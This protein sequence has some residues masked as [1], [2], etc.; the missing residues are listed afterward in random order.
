MKRL[1]LLLIF[2]LL[3]FFSYGKESIEEKVE[4]LIKMMTLEEKIGQMTQVDNSYLLTPEDIKNYYIGSVLSGGNSGPSEFTPQ[5][6]ADYIDTL[7]SYALKTRLRIPLLYGI[8]AVHGNGK[9]YSAVIFPHNIGLGCTRDINLVERCARITALESCAIGAYWSFAP[10]VA[11]VQDIR[12]GRT[13][14]S[15]S[16]DPE[17]V[18]QMAKAVIRGFHGKFLNNNDSILACP[19]H[20]VGDGG[21]KFG[22]GIN[23]LLDQGDTRISEKLLREIHLK[24]YI[25]AIE[26]GAKSIMVSF[27]SF[28]GKKIHGNKYL[29]T[30][31]LKGELKFR[32]FLVSDWKGIEQLQGNYEEQ[33]TTAINAG[34]DMVMVPDDYRKFINTLIDCVKKGKISI[35]RINDAVRRILKVKFEMGLFEHP[36]GNR[37]LLN[38]IGSEEHRKVA[39]EAVRKSLVILKNDNKILPLSKNIRKIC[40]VGYK[41]DDIG[42]QCGGWTIYWQGGFGKIT[43]GTTILNAIKKVVSKNTKITYVNEGEDIPKDTEIVIAVVGEKPYAEFQGDTVRPTIDIIDQRLLDK[44]FLKGKPVVTILIIGRPVD[45]TGII[46]KSKAVIAAWLPGTEGEGITDILFGDYKPTGKLS[47]SWYIDNKENLIFPFGYGLEY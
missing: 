3:I 42:A 2:I 14:E 29:L 19:K 11:V 41:A 35:S 6:W 17:L 40:V 13:Y 23:G 39:R 16:E 32:G 5:A 38:N 18:S 8:D 1:I 34:I 43:E 44:I 9:V 15:Y 31:V 25:Y 26:E 37:K 10:C 20:F 33:V 24:P 46:E 7:Q 45:L 36:Y 21:T 12:W 4:N 30:D 28:N 27:S 47:F 22:T